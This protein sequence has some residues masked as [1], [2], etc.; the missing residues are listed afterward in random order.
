MNFRKWLCLVMAVMMALSAAAMAE[1]AGAEDLQAQLDAANER[2]A[3]L[4]AEVEK[5]RP[6]PIRSSRA[7][8]RA[9]CSRA[10]WTPSP[11]SW[12]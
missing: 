9:W 11:R 7:S 5:Y 12:A 10:C 4:E 3:Q 2:I 8:L 1:T 6:T